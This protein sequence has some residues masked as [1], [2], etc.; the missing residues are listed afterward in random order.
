MRHRET[1]A[2]NRDRFQNNAV[3]LVQNVSYFETLLQQVKSNTGL[4]GIVIQFDKPSRFIKFKADDYV[5]MH[6]V[7]DETAHEK[8]VLALIMDDKLDD[9]IPLIAPERAEHLKTYAAVVNE[10]LLREANRI[11]TYVHSTQYMSQKEFAEVVQRDFIKPEQSFLFRARTLE[12]LDTYS[13][14][15][16][17]KEFFKKT[18][19]TQVKVD[20]WRVFLGYPKFEMQVD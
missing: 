20:S 16:M 8:R 12:F 18:L 3:H 19:T 4:E 2:Y 11:Y 10:S 5:A 1:G 17:L 15:V 13:I 7:L 6:R 9:V 14:L